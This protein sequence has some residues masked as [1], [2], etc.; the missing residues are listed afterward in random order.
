MGEGICDDVRGAQPVLHREIEAQ[1][2][3]DPVV[4]RDGGEVLVKEVLQAVVVGLDDEAPPPEIRP[5]VLYRLDEAPQA[6]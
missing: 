4:L 5:S 3:V 2:L 6:C 1:E